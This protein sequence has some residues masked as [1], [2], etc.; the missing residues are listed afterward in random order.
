MSGP[1]DIPASQRDDAAQ[2]PADGTLLQQFNA[3]LDTIEYAVLFMGPDLRSRIINR[4]FREMWGIS[5]EFIR[6]T[7]PTMA[8]LI[9][10][11][12]NKHHLYDIPEGEFE[13]F[14]AR[15]V[16]AVIKG[17]FSSEMRLRDGA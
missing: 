8:E 13:A 2:G 1:A 11:V 7:R 10:Y 4:A 6:T 3:V 12:H 14:L 17:S 15:R 5:D 9:K 16:E